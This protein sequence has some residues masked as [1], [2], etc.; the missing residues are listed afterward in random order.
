MEEESKWDYY[1]KG[2]RAGLQIGWQ[3]ARL[4]WILRG[5]VPKTFPED[6]KPEEPAN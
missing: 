6:K 5:E 2:L 4:Y 1:L 3:E